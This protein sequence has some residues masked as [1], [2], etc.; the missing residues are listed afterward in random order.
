MCVLTH[1]E[2]C[3][4][5]VRTA[6]ARI[7]RGDEVRV[8]ALTAPEGPFRASGTCLCVVEDE[9]GGFV[10]LYRRVHTGS[11]VY[12]VVWRF[13]IHVE[14]YGIDDLTLIG[15]PIKSLYNFK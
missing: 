9:D 7:D 1:G 3:E 4:S 5:D 6:S 12:S 11:G 15:L 13:R 8:R 2:C 14:F 10:Q